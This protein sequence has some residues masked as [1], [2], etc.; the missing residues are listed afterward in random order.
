MAEFVNKSKEA[1]K[2]RDKLATL[3]ALPPE[4]QQLQRAIEAFLAALETRPTCSACNQGKLHDQLRYIA[5]ELNALTFRV[6]S[7][8]FKVTKGSEYIQIKRVQHGDRA[9]ANR[10]EGLAEDAI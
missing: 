5:L 10:H 9:A 8:E 4:Y 3:P 6:A 1:Q 2:E 7:G